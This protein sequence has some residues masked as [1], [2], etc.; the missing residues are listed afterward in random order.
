MG[1]G[2]RGVG[3]DVRMAAAAASFSLG[4]RRDGTNAILSLSGQWDRN[5]QR[6]ASQDDRGESQPLRILI[7]FSV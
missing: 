6:V 3:R 5:G 2:G 7:K 1:S 4:Q